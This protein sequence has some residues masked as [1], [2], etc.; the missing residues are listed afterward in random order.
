MFDE[1]FL[2]VSWPEIIW[3]QIPE[4]GHTRSTASK[5]PYEEDGEWGAQQGRWTEIGNPTDAIVEWLV[6]FNTA[7][8]CTVYYYTCIHECPLSWL[9]ILTIWSDFLPFWK[10]NSRISLMFVVFFFFL[11]I[12][13]PQLSAKVMGFGLQAAYR[14]HGG[15][16]AQWSSRFGCSQSQRGRPGH[17]KFDSY[18]LPKWVLSLGELIFGCPIGS[19]KKKQ[20]AAL[21]RSSIHYRILLVALAWQS[22]GSHGYRGFQ[23]GL[24]IVA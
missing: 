12:I 4:V 17:K 24:G 11:N 2:E 9:W 19:Q 7:T 15:E 10:R 22:P 21:P 3:G 16:Q 13:H 18:R 23:L 1:F 20:N 14:W 8:T 6:I 5:M